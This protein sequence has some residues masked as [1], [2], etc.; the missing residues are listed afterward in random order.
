MFELLSYS[1]YIFM[2]F[3]HRVRDWV[4]KLATFQVWSIWIK[5][6][7]SKSLILYIPKRERG[8]ILRGR[9]GV[10]IDFFSEINFLVVSDRGDRYLSDAFGPMKKIV[11]SRSDNRLEVSVRDLQSCA[12]KIYLKKPPVQFLKN[13]PETFRICSRTARY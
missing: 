9:G 6:K 4:I 8:N 11:P 12:L 1:Y 13:H 7:R 2:L 3:S 10:F 5:I